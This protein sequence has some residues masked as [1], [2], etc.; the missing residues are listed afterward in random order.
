MRFILTEPGPA[1]LRACGRRA[2]DAGA[3]SFDFRPPQRPRVPI[4]RALA[5]D[6]ARRSARSTRAS[7]LPKGS[8]SHGIPEGTT[9]CLTAATHPAQGIAMSL[10]P[11]QHPVWQRLASGALP[12]L[13]TQHLG[14]QLMTK[15]LERSDIPPA[16]KASEIHAFFAKWERVLQNEVQQLSAL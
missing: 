2:R 5:P 9:A 6:Q 10:P 1:A 7:R 14:I 4:A 11:L 3:C 12:R 13:K 8:S 16:A 15:R